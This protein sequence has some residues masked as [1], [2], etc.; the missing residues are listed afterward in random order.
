MNTRSLKFSLTLPYAL[1]I[2]A[3][4]LLI[5]GMSYWVGSRSIATL[6][7]QL[8]GEMVG[9]I[10]QAVHHHVYGSGTVLEA[11]FPDGMPAP[12]DLGAELADLQTRF[13]AA[14]SLHTDPNDYVYYGNERG[15][16]YGLK[17]LG[18]EQAQVRVKLEPAEHR[19]IYE[20]H[21]IQGSVTDSS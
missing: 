8:M 9:R 11:A 4:T 21:G 14:T 10:S 1:L 5:S 17:R 13:W 15:Q 6:S 16:G 18:P 3:A 20:I 2:A 19:A 12:R 7:E